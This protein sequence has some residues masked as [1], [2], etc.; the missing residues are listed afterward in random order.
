MKILLSALYPYVFLLLYL[1]IPF[2]NY[3]RAL[4]N[5]LVI[6]LVVAFPFVVKKSDFKKLATPPMLLFFAFFVYLAVNS[7]FNGRIFDDFNIVKKVMIAAGLAI[8]YIPVNDLKSFTGKT[9]KIN[10]AIIASALAAIIFTIYNFVIITHNSGNFALVDSPQI[11]ESLLIDRVY[12]GL[13]CCLSIVI[14][15]TAIQKRYHPSNNYYLA[16]IILNLIFIVLIGSKIAMVSLV[17][18]ALVRQFYGQ[19]KLWKMLIAVTAVI[20]VIGLFYFIKNEKSFKNDS[21]ANSKSTPAF[22]ENSLTYELRAVV[23]KSTANIIKDE[24][25]TFFGI[26]FDETKDRLVANYKTS[27]NDPQKR[28]RF[29]E[30]RYNTHNQFL[31]FYLSAGF[32]SLLLFLLFIIVSFLVK[33]NQFLPIAMLALFVM[34][35]SVENLFNRQIG[36]YYAGF[37]LIVLMVSNRRLK[38]N[39]IKEL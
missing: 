2:D 14:S 1:I 10:T 8:L 17:V 27:I 3:I 7:I 20:A 23:W 32:V 22:I 26:G 9:G 13:L 19:R 34:Y 39:K 24:G 21:L 29:I 28:E 25:F 31:D 36:A 12:L 35:C 4:P 16:N 30:N 6:I 15:F 37:I 5:I 38:N 11:I 33:R 18:I